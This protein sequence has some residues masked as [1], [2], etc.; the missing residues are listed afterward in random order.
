MD[1]IG[2]IL[3]SLEEEDLKNLPGFI[4][5]FK[6]HS[7]RKD[8]QLLELYEVKGAAA[9]SQFSKTLYPTGNNAAYQAL[10]KR[11]IKMLNR[12]VVLK[13]MDNDSSQT[14][15]VLGLVNM[16]RHLYAHGK[17]HLGWKYLKKAERAADKN[18][19][20]EILNSIYV[21]QIQHITS[22]KEANHKELIAKWE[23]NKKQLR[24]SELGEIALSLVSQKIAEARKAKI[25]IDLNELVKGVLSELEVSSNYLLEPRFVYFM[26][27]VNRKMMM[28]EKD[29]FNLEPFLIQHYENIN[30]NKGFESSNTYYKIGFLYMIA[31]VLYRNRKFE[32]AL[33]YVAQLESEL[34]KASK[35][36]INEFGPKTFLL[37]G[38]LFIF[39]GKAKPAAALF[40]RILETQK[41]LTPFQRLATITN[42]GI[43]HFH[44]K[45][46]DKTHRALQLITH[47]DAWCEKVMGT[48]W[49]VKKSMM[50]AILYIELG[51]LTLVDSRIQ[52]IQ[53][54]FRELLS[55]PRYQRIGT[56]VGFLRKLSDV[57]TKD[58]IEK[59]EAA[60]DQ[61]FEWLPIELEDLQAIAFYSWLK[62]KVLGLDA[63]QVMMELAAP[64]P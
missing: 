31:H 8:L 22:A 57:P 49:V 21:L 20:F 48:E 59:L 27:S 3:D 35:I 40:G 28:L 14:S 51:E 4:K 9:R 45:E 12:F 34:G 61:S 24:R 55:Q 10:R 18:S 58:D 11:L 43:A 41:D 36:Q 30:T 39:M 64:R 63:Y 53:R 50:E 25:F 13:L 37:K 46:F 62:A 44:L 2:D 33:E 5:R 17:D 16:A 23:S 60:L 26:V 47:S 56:Y 1:S 52:Y 38:S 29:Y 19:L 32:S 54:S 6:G 7:H 42:L 15:E